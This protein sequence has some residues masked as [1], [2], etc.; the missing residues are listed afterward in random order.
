M[1]SEKEVIRD[2]KGNEMTIK[3]IKK[4]VLPGSGMVTKEL[5]EGGI[6]FPGICAWIHPGRDQ[7]PPAPGINEQL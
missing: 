1:G 4:R 6:K 5:W 2:K 3:E 7:A